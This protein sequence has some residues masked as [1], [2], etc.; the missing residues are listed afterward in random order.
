MRRN[1]THRRSSSPLNPLLAKGE[2]Q[3][4]QRPLESVRTRR[5]QSVPRGRRAR[6]QFDEKSFYLD[7]FRGRTLCFAFSLSDWDRSRAP[8]DF[9]RVLRDLLQNETRLIVLIG[10]EETA[11]D[12]TGVKRAFRRLSRSV[13]SARTAALFPKEDGRRSLA[14][15]FLDMR[16]GTDRDPS[17]PVSLNSVWSILRT[18]PLF[19]GCVERYRLVDIAREMSVRLRLPKLVLTEAEG[20]LSLSRSSRLS[21]M[22]GSTLGATLRA[23]E[24]EWAGIASRRRTLEAVHAA[25]HGG[26]DAVNLC[27]IDDLARELFTYEGS[28][29]LFTLQD[30]CRVERLGVDDFPSVERIIAHGQHEGYLKPRSREQITEILLN[31]YGAT[32][33]AHHLAGVCALITDP[34]AQDRAGEIAGVS[35]L[36]RF[37]GEGVGGKLVQRAVSDA[38]ELGLRY[39]FACTTEARA[40]VFFERQGFRRV[41]KEDVPRAKWFDYDPKRMAII[42]VFRRE[43]ES[44]HPGASR[45]PV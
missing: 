32:V 1:T 2:V 20:G 37:Q 45:G 39:V 30:Y 23:G 40:Q 35:T 9:G 38:A 16:A 43:L 19:I 33:G 13:L 8:T 5:T 17:G 34:Y 18:R 6:A 3:A 41:G 21:F 12:A 24:A 25:L 31:G 28:G 36:T 22:D 44:R 14:S 42:K 15:S 7:E 4:V 10:L 27:T 26:V 11:D 29:T